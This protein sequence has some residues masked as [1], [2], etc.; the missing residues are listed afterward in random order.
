MDESRGLF[1]LGSVG[2]DGD[3]LARFGFF[4]KGYARKG[5]WVDVC[6]MSDNRGLC[7]RCF[8]FV[9]GGACHFDS[10]GLGVAGF[11]MGEGKK[12]LT[13]RFEFW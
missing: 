12:R 7:R 2:D 8:G 4:C 3:N 11:G 1:Q 9:L 5:H 6:K 13:R 10:R